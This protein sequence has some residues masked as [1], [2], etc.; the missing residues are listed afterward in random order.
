VGT[1]THAPTKESFRICEQLTLIES[2]SQCRGLFVRKVTERDKVEDTDHDGKII[3][4]LILKIQSVTMYIGFI[5]LGMK[6][7]VGIS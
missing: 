6:F 5:C 3:L 4:K 1:Y 7:S 2:K